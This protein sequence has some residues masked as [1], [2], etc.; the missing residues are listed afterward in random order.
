MLL[1]ILV[2]FFATCEA[3]CFPMGPVASLSTPGYYGWQCSNLT[4]TATT[5]WAYPSPVCGNNYVC[6]YD[7][8]VCGGSSQLVCTTYSGGSIGL[9][10]AGYPCDSSHD[11][12][13]TPNYHCAD[14]TTYQ[15]QLATYFTSSSWSQPAF[16]TPGSGPYPWNSS[17]YNGVCICATPVSGGLGGFSYSTISSCCSSPNDCKFRT[18]ANGTSNMTGG[19]GVTNY[20]CSNP[21]NVC[22]VVASCHPVSHQC[23]VGVAYSYYNSKC[24]T[25]AKTCGTVTYGACTP[26]TTFCCSQ[27]PTCSTSGTYPNC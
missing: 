12:C 26:P 21:T 5:G 13:A 8:G 3:T 9:A 17:T 4:Y 16:P 27:E 2:V 18:Y 22:E 10:T 19:N 23:E 1:A 24:A 6:A 7:S 11:L 14:L 25:C 15:S 20:M